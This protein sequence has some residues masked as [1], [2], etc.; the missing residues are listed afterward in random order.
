MRR[1]IDYPGLGLVG[2]VVHSD[3]KAGR[4]ADELCGVAPV[5]WS[6]LR[7][8]Q[9]C[10]PGDTDAVVYSAADL[11]PREAVEDMASIL[12]SGK[13][14]VSFSVVPL[15]SPPRNVRHAYRAHRGRDDRSD[16]LDA[17]RIRR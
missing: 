1:V 8:L 16:A 4:D 11:R 2:L 10:R 6:P 9:L 14:A 13:N 17:R 12:R 3:A 15:V 5:G 7:I